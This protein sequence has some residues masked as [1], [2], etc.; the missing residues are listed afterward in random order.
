MI[1]IATSARNTKITDTT[2]KTLKQNRKATRKPRHALRRNAR[3]FSIA[4]RLNTAARTRLGNTYI[5]SPVTASTSTCA[6]ARCAILTREDLM[7]S[8]VPP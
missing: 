7:S 6:P 4:S 2:R 3:L 5:T 1:M 8:D